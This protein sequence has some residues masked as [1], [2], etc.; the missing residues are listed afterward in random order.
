[1]KYGFYSN[2]TENLLTCH[3]QH[4]IQNFASH[5]AFKFSTSLILLSRASL[6]NAN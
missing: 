6:D 3:E 5:Q 1:M 2:F 4:G